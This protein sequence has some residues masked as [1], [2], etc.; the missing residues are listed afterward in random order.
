MAEERD[1]GDLGRGVG[2]RIDRIYFATR[3]C[4]FRDVQYISF[5][6]DVQPYH[7]GCSALSNRVKIQV[8]KVKLRHYKGA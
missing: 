4:T 5:T 6:I 3:T 2:R 8:S 1:A 7:F